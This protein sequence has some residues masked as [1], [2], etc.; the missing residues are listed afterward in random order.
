MPSKFVLQDPGLV[1]QLF[2]VPKA[3]ADRPGQPL[4]FGF[5]D[6]GLEPPTSSLWA[7]GALIPSVRG[8][9]GQSCPGRARNPAGLGGIQAGQKKALCYPGS[10]SEY[11]ACPGRRS[12]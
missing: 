9:Q 6:E 11:V 10:A 12:V 8:G 3:L 4:P 7:A 1:T 5:P 2:R